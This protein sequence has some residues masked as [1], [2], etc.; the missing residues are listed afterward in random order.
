MP[1]KLYFFWA[2]NKYKWLKYINKADMERG[3]YY[4]RLSQRPNKWS[5]KYIAKASGT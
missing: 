3:D 1:K 2:R 5:I 4:Y